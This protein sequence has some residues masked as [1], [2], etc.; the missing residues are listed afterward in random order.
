MPAVSCTGFFIKLRQII[1][2]LA[3]VFIFFMMSLIVFLFALQWD[4]ENSPQSIEVQARD[5]GFRNV[6]EWSRARFCGIKTYDEWNVRKDE[7]ESST[8]DK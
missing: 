5:A 4:I 6:Y 8:L 7:F 1:G 2:L 3:L